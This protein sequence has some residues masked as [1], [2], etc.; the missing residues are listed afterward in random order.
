MAFT[1]LKLLWLRKGFL[2]VASEN[3][4]WGALIKGIPCVL[5]RVAEGLVPLT[6]DL[7][8]LLWLQKSFFDDGKESQGWNK[9]EKE[10]EKEKDQEEEE[11][12]EEED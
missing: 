4:L 8:L 7:K 11:D 10:K 12:E 6:T 1:A 9:E 2:E 3:V 5:F